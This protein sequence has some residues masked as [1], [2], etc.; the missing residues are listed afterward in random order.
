MPKPDAYLDWQKGKASSS[1]RQAPNALPPSPD[2]PQLDG[3]ETTQYQHTS[4]QSTSVRT[5]P[6][7]PAEGFK[8]SGRD[9]RE[10]DRLMRDAKLIE[11][12][13]A[14]KEQKRNPDNP[15]KKVPLKEIIPVVFKESFPGCEVIDSRAYKKARQ[16]YKRLTGE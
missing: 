7:S 2:R 13:N 10:I 16:E 1:G 5:V 11:Q 14:V 6:D 4:A 3:T 15:K 8:N 12:I 9:E